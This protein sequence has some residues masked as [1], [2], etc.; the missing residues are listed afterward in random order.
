MDAKQQL[1]FTHITISQKEQ[2]EAIRVAFGNTQ[3]VYT[4]A[5]LFAWQAD[6]GY[7][8]CL[9]DDAFL[10]KNN[11]AGDN[12]YLFPCGTYDGKKRMLDSLINNGCAELYFVSDEDKSFLEAEY[13]GRFS[14]KECRNDFSYLYDKDEQIELS[15]KDYKNLR[16]Q[17]NIG[18]A[19]A[20]NWEIEPLCEGNV[21]RALALNSRWAAARNIKSV[22]DTRAAETA[23][24]NFDDLAM[25]GLI[26]KADGEDTAYIAG[27]F[28]TPEIFDVSF[29]KVL[30]RR[31]DCYIKWALYCALPEETKTV[32]S[33]EDLGIEGLRTHKLLRRPKELTRVWKGVLN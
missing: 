25:W 1:T 33:E 19:V 29:C 18:R 3:Y 17:I 27:S 23:L 2:V 22:A 15:G 12:A 10:V 11:A 21:E 20:D 16:H 8:I 28:V 24:R 26:F 9:Q 6:E 5:S 4:F 31:C 30:D 7:E 32:D 14:F 13:P